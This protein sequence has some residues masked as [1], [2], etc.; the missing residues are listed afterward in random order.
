M[1]EVKKLPH[2][3]NTASMV[4]YLLEKALPLERNQHAAYLDNFFTSVQLF[5]RLRNQGIGAVGTTRPYTSRGCFPKALQKIK[6]GSNK[7]TK[8]KRNDLY[9][10][11]VDKVLCFMWQDD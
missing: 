2:L 3:T 6:D 9:A 8:L 4:V 5:K 7:V 11:P 1:V 10:A